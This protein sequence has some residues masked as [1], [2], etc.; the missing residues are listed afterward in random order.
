[1]ADALNYDAVQ[2][3]IQSA[4][5]AK[6]DFE[7]TVN[8]ISFI[9]SICQRLQGMP[10]AIELIAAWVRTLTLK[11]IALEI[12]QGLD[13]LT[14]SRRDIIE[15]HKTIRAVFDHSW[16]MLDQKEQQIFSALAVFRGGFTRDAAEKVARANLLMLSVAIDKSLLRHSD[17][18][19]YDMHE[20]I[21][22]YL[23]EKL[24]ESREHEMAV[25]DLH[26][27]YYADFMDN[28]TQQLKGG[29]QLQALDDINAEMANIRQSWLYGLQHKQYQKIDKYIEGLRIFHLYRA[30]FQNAHY[31]FDRAILLLES[32]SEDSM[33]TDVARRRLHALVSNCMAMILIFLSDL[34]QSRE[35]LV[36]AI[37]TLNQIDAHTDLAVVLF[38]L[39]VLEDIE[40]DYQSAKEHLQ[41]SLATYQEINDEFGMAWVK[42]WLGVVA[43]RLGDYNEAKQLLQ[44]SLDFRRK[45]GDRFGLAIVLAW[46]GKVNHL[47]SNFEESRH[48]LHES[49][50]LQIQ[51]NSQWGIARALTD[52]GDVVCKQGD[53][54]EAEQYI[55]ESIA[56]LRD[57]GDQYQLARAYTV[58][59]NISTSLNDLHTAKQHFHN[60]LQLVSEAGHSIDVF[61]TLLGIAQM[62]AIDNQLERA[63]SLVSMLLVY[64]DIPFEVRS[65]TGQLKLT[66]EKTLDADMV[67]AH[68]E[69]SGSESLEQVV[70]QLVID[71]QAQI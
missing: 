42:D 60:A 28:R 27:T 9:V 1:M 56:M 31:L 54:V 46:L 55:S 6:V 4:R 68:D 14:T 63:Y 24:S 36:E 57:L 62:M 16:Q 49:V 41:I 8:D 11:E 44:S 39:A 32:A 38:N 19:Y 33:S 37:D 61:Y 67:D 17:S 69:Q 10:L 43:Y 52:L 23:L 3:F 13:L 71:I 40:G 18:G 51:Q 59:G 47:T 50:E 5:R 12:S 26:C 15:R 35:I 66:L 21:R 34:Q 22:E 65:A 48:L 45:I 30:Q 64:S 29:N 58:A 70:S 2:L 7:P 20:L 53:F 25:H